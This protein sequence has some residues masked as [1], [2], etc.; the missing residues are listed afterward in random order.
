MLGDVNGKTPQA[1]SL[2]VPPAVVGFTSLGK[3]AEASGQVFVPM[4]CVRPVGFDAYRSTTYIV[5]GS[6]FRT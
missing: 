3:S 1:L 5:V 6:L 2:H 4:G